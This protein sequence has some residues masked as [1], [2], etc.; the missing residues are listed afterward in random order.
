MTMQRSLKTLV[1]CVAA[2]GLLLPPVAAA[3]L[4]FHS[5]TY[6]YSLIP[7]IE[8]MQESAVLQPVL[9]TLW[10]IVVTIVASFALVV[11]TLIWLHLKA[12]HLLPTVEW[13]STLPYIVPPI[14]LVSGVSLALR[15]LAPGFFASIVSLVPFYVLI[16]LPFTY[17]AVDTGLRALDLPTLFRAAE[18]LGASSLKVMMTVVLPNLRGSLLV[19]S[20]LAATMVSGEFVLSS[21]LLHKTFP[22]MLV[23]L[24]QSQVRL[25]AALSFIA[26]MATWALMT[27][28][29][30]ARSTKRS[31]PTAALAL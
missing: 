2:V 30:S 18:S 17:R 6:G 5:A 11:P 1:L 20:V 31:Q 12:P 19:G 21:L 26:M 7:V 8:K 29:M 10:L 25:A 3:L 13:L 28:L 23:E 24:G 16:T 9:N 27:L 15:P 22:T 14:A 4:G